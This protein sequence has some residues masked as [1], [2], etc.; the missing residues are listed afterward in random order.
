MTPTATA[1][2]TRGK[3]TTTKDRTGASARA[4]GHRSTLRQPPAPK[5]P[6]R[7]SG[8][9]GGL[10]HPRRV[11]GP[12]RPV[13]AP[14]LPRPRVAARKTARATLG[15]RAVAFLRMLPDHQLLDRIVRGRAWIPL[16]GILLAGIV[17]MQVEVLKLGA[18]MGASIERTTYLQSRNELLRAS[19]A[20]L[21][22]D[23]RIESLAAGMGMIMPAPDAIN[24]LSSR[25]VGY[26]QRA[27]SSIH[28]PDA[29]TFLASL[30]AASPAATAPPATGA[31]STSTSGAPVTPSTST[32][33]PAATSTPAVTSTAATAVTLPTTSSSSGG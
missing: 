19:V 30:P 32:S 3:R 10:A 31:P 14:R 13:A 21:A 27:A 18:R 29:A 2:G 11:S 8:P 15:A 17:A 33:A 26:L 16:L 5:A 23:Q 4:S 1:P 20:S 25:P 22:D 28:Q 12:D 24:F 7:V 6:R 9:A